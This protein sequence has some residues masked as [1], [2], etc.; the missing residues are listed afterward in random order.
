VVIA[1]RDSVLGYCGDEFSLKLSRMESTPETPAITNVPT[2]APP[3][4]EQEVCTFKFCIDEEGSG[5][6]G[7]ISDYTIVLGNIILIHSIEIEIASVYGEVLRTFLSRAVAWIS[8]HH[9][10][11]QVFILLTR[12]A[13]VTMR[14][15]W[16]LESFYF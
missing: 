11:H 5:S 12:G 9:I 15:G 2:L 13:P 4:C 7:A 10:R 14:V 6:K 16:R 1:A 8:P 3:N